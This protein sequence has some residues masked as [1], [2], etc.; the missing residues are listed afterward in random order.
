LTLQNTEIFLSLGTNLG[1]RE[2][3]LIRCLET[4]GAVEELEII[5]IS[6]IYETDPIGVTE[7]P[8]FL[9]MVVEIITSLSPMELLHTVKNI[10][11]K[12]GRK[13]TFR[14][15][16]RLIDIDILAYKNLILEENELFIPHQRLAE[17]LFVLVPLKEIAPFFRHPKTKKPVKELIRNC[18]DLTQVRLKKHYSEIE[19]KLK[20]KKTHGN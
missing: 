1:D 4:L 12:L 16:P 2:E 13:E 17:R 19:R 14:W 8:D 3:N 18:S 11:K 7:Q 6:S 10:E 5:R 9:N 20:W 15:G